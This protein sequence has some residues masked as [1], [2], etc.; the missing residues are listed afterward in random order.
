VTVAEKMA[1]SIGKVLDQYA[2]SRVERRRLKAIVSRLGMLSAQRAVDVHLLVLSQGAH[3]SIGARYCADWRKAARR[4]DAALDDLK[5]AATALDTSVRDWMGDN[6]PFFP[7]EN[8]P[9]KALWEAIEE[10]YAARDRAASPRAAKGGPGRPGWSGS[11][12][13]S[14]RRCGVSKHDAEFLLPLVL[15]RFAPRRE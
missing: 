15:R 7:D 6:G 3:H 9:L 8:E 4:R 11:L 2:K 5:R 1:R 14:L 13:A 12:K 10:L